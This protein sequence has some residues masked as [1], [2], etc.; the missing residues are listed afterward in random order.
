[1]VTE[2][3]SP[4][5]GGQT[6]LPGG[7]GR[8]LQQADQHALRRR[9]GRHRAGA[10][11][12]VE[13]AP[14]AHLHGAHPHPPDGRAQLQRNGPGQLLGDAHQPQPAALCARQVLGKQMLLVQTLTFTARE[15][16]TTSS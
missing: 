9:A 2:L 7:P 4:P 15:A 3:F 14:R 12:Q 13:G 1:M 8:P 10:P 5:A 11:V 16:F 6:G